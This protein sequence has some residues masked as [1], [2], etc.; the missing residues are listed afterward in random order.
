[1]RSGAPA[2]PVDSTRFPEPVVLREPAG[3]ARRPGRRLSRYLLASG[4]ALACDYGL[5]L[6]LVNGV[7]LAAGEAGALSYGL[8]IVVHYLLSRAF[9]FAPGW[10]NRRRL[11]ELTGFAITGAVGMALTVAILEVGTRAI[12]LP[13][14]VAKAVAVIAS[15]IL[16]YLLRARLVFRV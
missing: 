4:V 9:V 1:M 6:W 7:A 15:F 3:S 11:V 12:A 5:L 8:G 2:P 16:T 10:L 13:V 14:P